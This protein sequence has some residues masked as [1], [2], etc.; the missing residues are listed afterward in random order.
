MTGGVANAWGLRPARPPVHRKRSL[1]VAVAAILIAGCGTAGTASPSATPAA[2]MASGGTSDSGPPS[3]PMPSLSPLEAERY[4]CGALAF[5][6]GILLAPGSA[7]DDPDAAADAL[8]TF[9]VSP[10]NGG[11]MP[12]TRWHRLGVTATTAEFAAGATDGPGYVSVRFEAQGGRWSLFSWGSC[13]PRRVAPAGFVG[14]VWWLPNGVPD[15]ADRSLTVEMIIDDCK[16]GP[17]LE[18]IVD[19][20]VVMTATEAWMVLTARQGGPEPC[21]VGGI[22]VQGRPTTVEVEL[23]SEIG[24]RDLIDG[25]SLPARDATAPPDWYFGVGG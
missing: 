8:R 5:E 11:F 7:E 12:L 9:L 4:T 3:E 25:S 1:A 16:V 17:P 18:S 15:P 23:P 20:L 14:L 13:Q 19:P 22:L 21:P 10:Q 2:S 24:A 6:A